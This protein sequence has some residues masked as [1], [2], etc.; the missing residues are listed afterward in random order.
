MSWMFTP[1]YQSDSRILPLIRDRLVAPLSRNRLA[2][3]LLARLVSGAL[4]EPVSGLGRPVMQ[5]G[6]ARFALPPGG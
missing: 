4:V 2:G 6:S 3:H 5:A 1:F